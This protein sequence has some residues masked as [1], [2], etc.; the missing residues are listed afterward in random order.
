MPKTTTRI[1][2]ALIH[3]PVINR[4]GQT[5]T[6]SITNLDIH[7]ISRV[8]RTYGIRGF[9]LVTPLKDQQALAREIID[10]WTK[11]RGGRGNPHRREALLL[12]QIA[13]TL[14]EAL[15]KIKEKE[16][17]SPL[18]IA[19]GASPPRRDLS[20]DAAKR[21]IAQGRPLVILLGTASGLSPLVFQRADYVLEPLCGPTDYNHLS[22]RAAAAIILDRLLGRPCS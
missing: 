7:D 14:F 5:I 18:T 20:F 3:H 13:G 15:E 9:F 10:Y 12:C 6:S 22:V 19:T 11:G 1:Y 2:L 17:I 4:D 21:L 8:A 16:G